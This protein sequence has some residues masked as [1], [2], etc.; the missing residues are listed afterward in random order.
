M[1][2]ALVKAH[3]LG[4]DEHKP[5]LKETRINAS[6]V[7]KPKSSFSTNPTNLSFFSDS[8]QRGIFR[9]IT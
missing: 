5:R 4:Y 7:N 1:D 8:Y 3:E 6:I 9:I 2:F